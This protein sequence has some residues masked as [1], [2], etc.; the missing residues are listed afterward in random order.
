MVIGLISDGM[1]EDYTPFW[2]RFDTYR[3]NCS[4]K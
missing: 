3:V 1:S 2:V 4:A